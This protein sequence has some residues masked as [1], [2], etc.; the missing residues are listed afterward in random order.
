VELD[1]WYVVAACLQISVE[2]LHEMMMRLLEKRAAGSDE[3]YD[4][5]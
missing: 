1:G 4:E 2:E 3:E 5:Y